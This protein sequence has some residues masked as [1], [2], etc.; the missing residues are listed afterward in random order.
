MTED[1]ISSSR[2][3]KAAT[4]A[5]YN[6]ASFITKT[7]LSLVT[8]TIFIRVLS[9]DLLGTNSLFTNILSMLSLT[10]M[11]ISTAVGYSLYAPLAKKD[12]KKISVIMSFYRKAYATIGFIVLFLGIVLSFFLSYLIKDFSSI[13][14]PYVIYYLFLFNTVISYFITYKEVLATA[15]QKAYIISKK[16]II[17]DVFTNVIQI[18]ILLVFKNY[19]FYLIS[20]IVIQVL[21]RI[22]I[23]IAITREYSFVNFK[24]DRKMPT[25]DIKSIKTNVASMFMHKI[26]DYC[27][28]STD[29][30]IISAFI[31][32]STVGVYS[33]YLTIITLLTTAT[34]MIFNSLT[35]TLGNILTTE[36]KQKQFEAYRK[37]DFAG[38]IIFS[39]C[40]LLL[41]AVLR[42]FIRLWA[43]PDYVIEKPIEFLMVAN[44][45]L[46]GMRIT[47]NVIKN[48]AGQYKIDRY[49]PLIQAAINLIVSVFFVKRLGLLG[50]IFG[51]ITSSVLVPMWQRPYLV[52]KHVLHRKSSIY[53]KEHARYLIVLIL[54]CLAF[55]IIS[56]P[57]TRIENTLVEMII[58]A[59]AATAIFVI[60][61]VLVF[62]KN[63]Y[64]VYFMKLIQKRINK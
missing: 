26:G 55:Y 45:Y 24:T 21:G 5:S 19:I 3:K 32:V 12:H 38:Y 33:N 37:I 17:I 43:G 64:F 47:I 18:I 50:A 7:L 34:S 56:R 57:I 28:N 48:S 22:A 9:S 29:S 58:A 41:I 54:E 36:N 40:T 42:Y 10:E 39:Y 13:K 20:Q 49:A 1:R 16:Q 8:R 35:S 44:F 11:G 31:N 30:L 23:N 6:F 2:L 52:Y 53:F 15:D 51:T 62:Y 61:N 59:V 27:I 25:A 63:K 46:V 14:S 60:V 4:N